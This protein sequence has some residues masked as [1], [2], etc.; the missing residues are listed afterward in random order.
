MRAYVSVCLYVCV[1]V[2]MCVCDREVPRALLCLCVCVLS[3]RGPAPAHLLHKHVPDPLD[4]KVLLTFIHQG[5]LLPLEDPLEELAVDADELVQAGEELLHHLLLEEQVGHHA[6]AVDVAHDLEGAE[7]VEL[8][9]HQL[10]GAT[11]LDRQGCPLADSPAPESPGLSK[12]CLRPNL[13]FKA[14]S[15]AAFSLKSFHTVP[16]FH[17]TSRCFLTGI[18]DSI[19][20]KWWFPKLPSITDCAPIA[21]KGLVFSLVS[22]AAEELNCA[23]TGDL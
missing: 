13:N 3:A 23:V 8:R 22:A 11:G 5:V 4:E 15:R 10:W 16:V 20:L 1:S 7:V 2:Y 6:P 19:P 21:Q 18:L 14:G 9:L 17:G 12:G